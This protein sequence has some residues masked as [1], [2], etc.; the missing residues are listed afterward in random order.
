VRAVHAHKVRE[1]VHGHRV[2]TWLR[3]HSPAVAI[4]VRLICVS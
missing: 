1:L 2:L 3:H 4:A